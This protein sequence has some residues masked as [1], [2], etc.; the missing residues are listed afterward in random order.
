MKGVKS[1]AK[2]DT[3]EIERHPSSPIP[4]SRL[5]STFMHKLVLVKPSHH[6]HSRSVMTKGRARGENSAL[7][8]T[9]F[10]STAIKTRQNVVPTTILAPRNKDH[11]QR[12]K[13]AGKAEIAPQGKV[14]S[15]SYQ[16][17]CCVICLSNLRTLNLVLID[18]N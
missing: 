2:R 7:T 8:T 4:S 3:P 17:T 10:K 15:C 11:A 18:C 6:N 1:K 12:T 13:R 5:I 9:Q 14:I 16:S